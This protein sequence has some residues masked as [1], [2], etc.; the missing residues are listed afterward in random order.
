MTRPSW[1][2]LSKL[3]PFQG[4]PSMNLD[5]AEDL[6]KRIINIPSNSMTGVSSS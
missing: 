4:Y 6:A 3:N 2:L 5:T 1:T